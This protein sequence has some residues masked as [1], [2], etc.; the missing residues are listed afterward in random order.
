M[1]APN[2]VTSLPATQA[3]YAP[4]QN[5]LTNPNVGIAA[6]TNAR[7][8]LCSFRGANLNTTGDT[9]ISPVINSASYIVT[10]V[11]F[12]NASISLSTAL[13]AVN[14]GAAGSGNVVV[15]NVAL[16]GNTGPTVAIFPTVVTATKALNLSAQNMYLNVGTSQGAAATMDVFVYG[17]DVS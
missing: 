2:V 17:Y 8:L 10:D 12:T 5:G 14:T 3:V 15:A 4:E 9:M 6:G 7:R 16:S 11:V 1:S 13:A